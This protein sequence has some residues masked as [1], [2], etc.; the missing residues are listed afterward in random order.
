M[1]PTSKYAH[2]DPVVLLQVLNKKYS[3][4]EDWINGNKLVINQD[5][6]HL[7]IM[8]PKK[9]SSKRQLV[10]IQAGIF[11]INTTETEKMLG[12]HLHQSMQWNYH[13]RDSKESIMKQITAKVNGLKKIAKN[14]TFNTRLTVAKWAV[15]SK[16]VYLITVWGGAQKY[17]LKGL[18]VQ[19]LTAART[20]CGFFSWGWNNK[21]L[22]DRVGWLAIRQLI[23]YHTLIQAQKTIQSGKPSSIFESISTQH[24]YRTRNATSGHIRY[25]KTFRGDSSLVTA[26][27]KH[28]AVHWYNAVPVSVRTG[29]LATVKHKLR[30]WVK[31]NVPVDWG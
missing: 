12:A 16:L 17:L 31:Q 14:T 28:R 27:F 18:Q 30:K 5:K 19:Q 9:I 8:G 29:S 3:L 1:A 7:M 21:K 15:M 4:L 22:L 23:F 13:I 6:T 25:G 26:S 10:S 2:Q 24:P 11:T 20:V